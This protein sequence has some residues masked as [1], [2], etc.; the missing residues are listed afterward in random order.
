MFDKKILPLPNKMVM[1]YHLL[2]DRNMANFRRRM[3]W[4]RS[5][6][7]DVHYIKGLDRN[8]DNDTYPF[9]FDRFVLAKNLK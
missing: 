5:K 3:A 4:L 8:F 6:Y 1:E 7:H 9:T 2:K